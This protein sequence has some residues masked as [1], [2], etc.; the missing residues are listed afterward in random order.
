MFDKV[1][2][3]NRGEIAARIIRTCQRM[4]IATVAV[5]S[6]ADSG[7]LHT[8]MADQSVCI[9]GAAARDS[10]LS[11]DAVLDA[12]RATGANAIHPGY[13]FLSEN[14]ELPRRC[15]T[16]GVVFI[17]PGEE[18]LNQMG[19][20]L[21]ARRVARKSGL[22]VMPGTDEPV[23]DDEAI[24]KAWELG[25]PMMVKATAG[26]GGIGI[27]VVHSMEELEPIVQRTR[28]TAQAA[29]ADSSL[30]YERYLQGAS[31][32]EVQLIADQFGSV[33][34][35]HE[36]D[37]SIQ[38]RNQKL[39]E[40][41]PASAKLPAEV[42]R[43]IGRLSRQLGR[44]VG[45]TNAGTVEFL[46]TPDGHFYFLEMN[47]RLQV[48]HG[49]SELLT[50][51]D[52]VELQLQSA[53][54]EPFSLR[55]RDIHATGHAIE[56]RVYPEDPDTCLPN[57]GV[58][59]DVHL[60]EGDNVRVDTALC[61]GYEVS[62]HYEPLLAKVMA[63]GPDRNA[64]IA[65]LDSALADFRLEGVATNIPLL[66]DVLVSPEFASGD[67]NTGTLPAIL[68]RRQRNRGTQ[69]NGHR[70]VSISANG[71]NSQGPASGMDPRALAAAIGAAAVYAAQ[72]QSPSVGDRGSRWRTQGRR[73]LF[74]SRLGSGSW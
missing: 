65:T 7:A 26:G 19:D 39:I 12:C 59:T 13:G 71:A 61:L 38:R 47:P 46:V 58:V 69:P 57:V 45:Y 67:Y 27:H 60:P 64:A 48:E 41:T 43:Q 29:F 23:S 15:K 73:D 49:V 34:H 24:S 52:I 53:A 30:F 31:H 20:K 54:G 66:R 18:V 10:Y 56:A 68:E 44:E 42:R 32:I 62:L 2:V 22:P 50:G 55:Q 5:Y 25:F 21:S 40:E 6:E 11:I 63:W 72:G 14:S 36:R 33:L 4:G 1:L 17:G 35:L 28:K 9:G 51:R 8:R 16:E 3:A 70:N 74:R 37:C